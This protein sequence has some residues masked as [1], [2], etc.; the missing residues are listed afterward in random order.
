MSLPLLTW[1]TRGCTAGWPHVL[2]DD[3]RGSTVFGNIIKYLL[4]S[5]KILGQYTSIRCFIK[6]SL[7]ITHLV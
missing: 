1:E 4:K 3:G 5:L 6:R 7:P 2:Q